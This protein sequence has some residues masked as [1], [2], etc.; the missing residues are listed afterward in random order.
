MPGTVYLI[1]CNLG[2]N[3]FKRNLPAYNLDVINSINHFVVEN[4]RTA[5]RFLK[6]FGI[7][8][9]IDDLH[10]YEIGKH[11][12]QKKYSQYLAPA[13][14][15]CNIGI[16]S[17]AGCPGVADPGSDIVRIA[18][19]NNI[20]VVPLVGPS[21]ILLSL[22][23]SGMNG[24][25]FCFH[26]YLPIKPDRKRHIK[27]LEELSGKHNQTQ[28][29]IEAPYRNDKLL[30][31]ILKICNPQTRLCIA[32]NITLDNEF[33]K[34]ATIKEWTKK[35]IELHKQPVVFLLAKS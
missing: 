24:Q 31:D 23:A 4:I 33:I 28:I 6:L 15:D 32:T 25:S 1:P 8:A 30:D 9:K 29:F 2:D 13:L 35:D 11:S 17:E 7:S 18:H 20:R 26:G 21:S 19:S 16:L 12:D 5:R 10:F 27:Q 34:T 22:M 14:N 3:N